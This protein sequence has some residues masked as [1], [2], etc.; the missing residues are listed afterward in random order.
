MRFIDADRLMTDE[1]KSTYYHLKNGDTAIPIIDIEHAPAIEAYTK[2]EVLNM[3]H[4]L[5]QEIKNLEEG[6]QDDGYVME[7][8][9]IVQSRIDSFIDGKTNTKEFIGLVTE[10]VDPRLCTYREYQG[11]PYYG[12]KY[13]ENGECFI[14]FGTFK[15]E[16]LSRYLKDYFVR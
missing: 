4:D 16:V 9:K 10:D 7:A 13:K 11:K 3:F 14:G 6:T 5:L 15:I 12:I 1:M 8:E 2:E